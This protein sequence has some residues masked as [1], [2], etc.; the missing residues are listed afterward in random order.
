MFLIG[1]SGEGVAVT[2]EGET[3]NVLGVCMGDLDN[4]DLLP[5]WQ[6]DAEFSIS[7][8]DGEMTRGNRREACIMVGMVERETLEAPR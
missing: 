5:Q 7:G 2:S 6:Y 1:G 4:V 3:P 8:S